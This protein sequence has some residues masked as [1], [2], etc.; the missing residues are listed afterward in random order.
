M[1]GLA[2]SVAITYENRP[3]WYSLRNIV[4]KYNKT[5]FQATQIIRMFLKES[6]I[7]LYFLKLSLNKFQKCQ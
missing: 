3:S 5:Y 6:I 1:G 7:I 2:E 4:H